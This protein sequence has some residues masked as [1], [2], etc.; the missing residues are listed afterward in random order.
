MV[1]LT[2]NFAYIFIH[3]CASRSL[4]DILKKHIKDCEKNQPIEIMRDGVNG[5]KNLSHI[6]NRS[7]Y[8][9]NNHAYLMSDWDD[10]DFPFSF[11]V[12]RNP[13]TRFLSSYKYS[14]K[15]GW[16]SDA[17]SLRDFITKVRKLLNMTVSEREKLNKSDRLVLH[18]II[19]QHLYICNNDTVCV[20][21]VL[22]LENIYEDF[23]KLKKKLNISDKYKFPKIN[24]TSNGIVNVQNL[25]N[26]VKNDIYDLYH[27]DFKLLNYEK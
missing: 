9:S 13:Y 20:D 19:P 24:Y 22:K 15:N 14:L 27:K 18:H 26:D 11:T 23:E 6:M 2:D 8:F 10:F 12:T 7:N 17:I 1:F 21:L 3:K 25:E 16:I 5:K 4:L